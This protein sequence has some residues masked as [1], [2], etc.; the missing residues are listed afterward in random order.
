MPVYRAPA[1]VEEPVFSL[2]AD[3]VSLA[4]LPAAGDLRGKE[5]GERQRPPL[6]SSS[7]LSGRTV[8]HIW[9]SVTWRR[10]CTGNC[11]QGTVGRELLA[12]SCWQGATCCVLDWTGLQD[13]RYCTVLDISVYSITLTAHVMIVIEL[14]Y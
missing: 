11:R 9:K 1:G 8:S 5:G 13:L 7:S 4:E 3:Q 14:V 6:T 10:L 12:G 2:P